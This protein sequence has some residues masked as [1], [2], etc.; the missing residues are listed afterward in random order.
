MPRIEFEYL[1]I[2]AV[3][4]NAVLSHFTKVSGLRDDTTEGGAISGDL[5][6]RMHTQ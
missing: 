2:H 5:V 1:D 3:A 4:I 6:L